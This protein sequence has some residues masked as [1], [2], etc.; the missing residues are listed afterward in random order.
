MTILYKEKGEKTTLM[1]LE[2]DI[3]ETCLRWGIQRHL[4]SWTFLGPL[5]MDSQRFFMLGF[6]NHGISAI[7]GRKIFQGHWSV[8]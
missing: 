6:S 3:N 1:S 8:S 2:E 4:L 7:N 5:E